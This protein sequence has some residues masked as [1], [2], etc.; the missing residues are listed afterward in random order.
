VF[1]VLLSDMPAII[2]SYSPMQL[3]SMSSGLAEYAI[4]RTINGE[5][6]IFLIYFLKGPD[7]VWR[8]DA[9]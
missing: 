9:M 8:I 6:R 5:D 1:D 3:V 4:N 7:D 2:A